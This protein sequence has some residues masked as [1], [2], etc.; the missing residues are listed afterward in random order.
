[1]QRAETAAFLNQKGGVGKTTSVVN[2][3]AGLSIL[4]KRVLIVDLDPQSHLTTFLDLDPVSA[5]RTIYGVLRG[6]AQPRD[7][8]IEKTLRARLSIDGE[9]SPLKISVITS[10]LDLADAER[11]LGN[12]AEREHLLKKAIDNVSGDFDYVLFDCAPGLGLVSTNALA[13]AQKVFIP[14]QTEYLALDSLGGLLLKVETISQ[15]LGLDL[16]IGGLIATRFDARKVLS[17]T[18]VQTLREQFGALLM[19][20]MIRE[21]IALAESPRFGQDIFSYRPRSFGA[22]DYLN[23]SL[24]IIGRIARADTLFSVERGGVITSSARSNIAL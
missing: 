1:M 8:I 4:G 3:G 6:D 22:E 11:V 5:D 17:R 21:N 9:E 24:E 23:L 10:A 7:A 16:K 15:R 13:A 2:I 19:D 20:T 12:E 18:I 14:V